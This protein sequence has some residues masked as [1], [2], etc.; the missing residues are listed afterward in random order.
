MDNIKKNLLLTKISNNENDN[1]NKNTKNDNNINTIA[2]EELNKFHEL[3]LR[4]LEIYIKNRR[5][6]GWWKTRVFY[7][8]NNGNGCPKFI[9]EKCK[10][11]VNDGTEK[12]IELQDIG[13][14]YNNVDKRGRAFVHIIPHSTT[15]Y[16]NQYV[17]DYHLLFPSHKTAEIMKKKT[18]LLLNQM[19]FNVK[20]MLEVDVL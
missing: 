12:G 14:I 16:T 18:L 2:C 13:Y 17:R 9:I 1:D 6:K 11:N 5:G 19:G 4:G 7:L 10:K 15:K 3:L 8:G 20:G